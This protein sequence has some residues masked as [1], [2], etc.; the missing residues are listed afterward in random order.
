MRAY[1]DRQMAWRAGRNIQYVYTRARDAAHPPIL[2]SKGVSESKRLLGFVLCSTFVFLQLSHSFHVTYWLV[3][4]FL[5]LLSLA[6]ALC[7]FVGTTGD[8]PAVSN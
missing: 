3:L 5:C 8:P 4:A 2:F 6:Y 7:S 1:G